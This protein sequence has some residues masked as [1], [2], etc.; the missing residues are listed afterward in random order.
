MEKPCVGTLLTLPAVDT[1]TVDTPSQY[2]ASTA[3]YVNEPIEIPNPS[4]NVTVI[5]EETLNEYSPA[6]P[7]NPQ[8]LRGSNFCFVIIY[9]GK[10]NKNN[11]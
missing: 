10:K 8:T 6:K 7:G 11:K 3:S 5:A 4:F 1:P 2:S 9:Y